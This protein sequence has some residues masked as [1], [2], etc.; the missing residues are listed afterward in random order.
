VR[1]D[2]ELGQD[3]L[4]EIRTDAYGRRFYVD[5]RH[6][7]PRAEGFVAASA[8]LEGPPQAVKLLFHPFRFYVLQQLL[9]PVIDGPRPNI[10]PH[11]DLYH[12]WDGQLPEAGEVGLGRVQRLH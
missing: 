10:T 5:V 12:L 1:S 3:G 9:Q 8:G 11:V 6:A 4:V 7:A 2:E